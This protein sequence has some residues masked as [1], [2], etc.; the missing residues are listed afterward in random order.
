MATALDK[1]LD[2]IISSRPKNGRR[3]PNRNPRTA[4]TGGAKTGGAAGATR[5]RYAGAV[6]TANGNRVVAPA[7]LVNI[8][9]DATKIIVS[10]LPRDVNESQI[11]ELF[12]STVGPLREVNLH[13]DAKG[14]SKGTA[15]VTFSRKGD[16]NK[17]FTQYNNR[18]IDGG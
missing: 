2:D 8:Q 14:N 3:R 18:L 15:S 9:P 5:A 1:S 11:K 4:G 6:P 7:S 12:A 17:A 10:N 13:Y 16:G